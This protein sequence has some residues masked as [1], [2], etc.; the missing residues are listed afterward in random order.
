VKVRKWFDSSQPQTLQGAVV[1]AY[2]DAVLSVISLL[3]TGSI[4]F[5]LLI[6]LEVAA[7][8]VANERRIAYY[9][10]VGLSGLYLALIVL[11]FFAGPA[12]GAILSL[13]FAVVL[14]VLLINPQS[15]EYQRIWFH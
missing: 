2:I 10:A 9:A 11:S 12:F 8:G 1:L 5:L 3:L 14:F 7:V 13:L 4:V 15:R 6:L